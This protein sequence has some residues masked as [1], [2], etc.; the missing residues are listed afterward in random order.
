MI[1]PRAWMRNGGWLLPFLLLAGCVTPEAEVLNRTEV[2]PPSSHVAVLLDAPTRRYKTIAIL[3]D[4][5]GGSPEEINARLARKAEELGADAV[6]I[7]GV[8]DKTETDWFWY[9]GFH[10]P[11]DFSWPR[12]R[13]IR[14][15]YR[16]TRAR[17][18]KYLN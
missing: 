15:T 18:L 17:A 8:Q 6:W 10:H 12:Y 1:S 3:R 14:H 5:Y 2:L 7:V 13:P 9:D 11:Y 16:E 4:T